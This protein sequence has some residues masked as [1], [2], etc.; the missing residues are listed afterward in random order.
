MESRHN[1]KGK[2]RQNMAQNITYKILEM[3]DLVKVL[4]NVLGDDLSGI[5]R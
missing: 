1:K 5:E 3:G 2:K 4:P